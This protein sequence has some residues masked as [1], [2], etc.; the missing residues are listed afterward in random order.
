V[1]EVPAEIPKAGRSV[2]QMLVGVL[3]L[4]AVLAGALWILVP[5]LS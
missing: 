1:V 2:G 4:L 5:L 3:T